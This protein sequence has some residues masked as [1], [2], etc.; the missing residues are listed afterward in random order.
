[1][2][3][4]PLSDRQGSAMY[5]PAPG[6]HKIVPEVLSFSIMGTGRKETKS[7]WRDLCGLSGTPIDHLSAIR[8]KGPTGSRAVPG[9]MEFF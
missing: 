9:S 4:G 2:L 5:P 6:F 1:M 3:P 7:Y 8:V